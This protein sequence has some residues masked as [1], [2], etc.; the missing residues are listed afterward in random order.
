MNVMLAIQ[1]HFEAGR[2]VSSEKVKIPEYRH[3]IVVIPD[4][5]S[6]ENSN[7][8]AWHKFLDIIQSIDGEEVPV[9]FER[10]TLHREVE[11]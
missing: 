5:Q 2:F 11:I 7:G 3:V 8:R 4:Q 10:A 6:P 1:G 9:E